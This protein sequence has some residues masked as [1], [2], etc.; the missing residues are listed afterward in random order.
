MRIELKINPPTAT[1]QQKKF[2]RFS[3]QVYETPNVRNARKVLLLALK[4]NAPLEPKKGAL[5]V[6]I[7]WRFPV[8]DKKKEWLPKATAPDLDNLAK[9]LL[10]CMTKTG[11]WEDDRQ[12]CSLHL[13]KYYVNKKEDMGITID[14]KG[15]NE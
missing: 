1:Q 9:M 13:S 11:Y 12:V 6:E 5:R 15:W 7:M 8:K 14:V 4:P 10:D 3:K 2:N